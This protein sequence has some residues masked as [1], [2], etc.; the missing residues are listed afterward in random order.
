MAISRKISDFIGKAS[1]IRKM[2]E[3]AARMRADGKGPVFLVPQ[4]LLESSGLNDV[5]A[6][7]SP[8][9][10]GSEISHRL[11]RLGGVK[12]VARIMARMPSVLIKRSVYASFV[13]DAFS[14]PK[15]LFSYWGYGVYVGKKR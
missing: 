10:A 13:K 9:T 14:T 6:K 12:G 4:E 11:R 7:T 15:E 2:F 8:I 3:E 5:V 1:F